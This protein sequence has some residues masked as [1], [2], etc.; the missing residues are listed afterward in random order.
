MLSRNDAGNNDLMSSSDLDQILSALRAVQ[1]QLQEQYGVSGMWV[2]GSYVRGQ[3]VET[4]D[5]DVLVEFERP[6]M[7][8]LKFVELENKVSDLLGR[9][10]DLVRRSALRRG[11]QD[12]VLAEAVAV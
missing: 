10:V 9:K 7:T 8:L 1:P 6:G 11:F 4:S 2:F 12:N 3:H 5:V